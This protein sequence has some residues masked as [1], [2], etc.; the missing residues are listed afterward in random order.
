[1]GSLSTP[2]IPAGPVGAVLSTPILLVAIVGGRI[3]PSFT[4]NWLSRRGAT[5]LPAPFGRF[6][7]AAHV[8][9]E[10]LLLD[11]PGEFSPCA[12]ALRQGR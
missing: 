12:P 10:C 8:G 3:I 1:M 6:E 7:I 5:R 2:A 4:R 11:E 9:G